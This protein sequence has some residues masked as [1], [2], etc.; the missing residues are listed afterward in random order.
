MTGRSLVQRRTWSSHISMASLPF[1]LGSAYLVFE[2]NTLLKHTLPVPG[3]V[4]LNEPLLAEYCM[5]FERV[6]GLSQGSEESWSLPP[7]EWAL[8]FGSE[9]ETLGQGR[10]VSERPVPTQWDKCYLSRP[11]FPH[12]QDYRLYVHSRDPLRFTRIAFS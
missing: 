10:G 9:S 12:L 8:L 2:R 6:C 3:R 11:Q 5:H 1:F 7:Q 4:G